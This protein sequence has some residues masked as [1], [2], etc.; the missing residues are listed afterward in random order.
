MVDSKIETFLKV[1]EYRSYSKAALALNL[2]QPAVSQQIKRLEEYY[3]CQLIEIRGHSVNL[4]PQGEA[5]Y[6]YAHLQFANEE[7]LLSQM[8]KVK[9]VIQ[10]GATLS[11]ADYYLPPYLGPYL[12]EQGELPSLT[13][14]NTKII[15]DMLL[16]NE[17]YC[18]FIEG[19]FDKSL[20]SFREFCT[21]RFCPVARRGHPLANKN[22][23]IE[24]IHKY[25]LLL[26]EQGSGTREIYENYLYQNND[27]LL[28]SKS[29]HEISSF[30]VIKQVL[31]STDAV[32]FMYEKVASK[33]VER[34][35]LS[36]LEI[37]G[38]HIE[39]PL[40][41]IYPGNSL[42]SGRIELFYENLLNIRSQ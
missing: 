38:F 26:R 34:G 14:K 33:E 42:I 22:I 10:V 20:F 28:S 12:A 23:R 36:Y 9:P 32:S 30:G 4:T 21:T 37:E 39:R 24:E 25:P 41:F 2:T 18:A 3:A 11:I 15:I 6:H 31:R 29:V 16:H 35:E 19:I 27:S 5:L 40:Y 7:Q 13:V 1:V 17:L 8:A